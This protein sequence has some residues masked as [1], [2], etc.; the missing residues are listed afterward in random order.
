METSDNLNRQF[1]FLLAAIFAATSVYM[2]L[3]KSLLFLPAGAI[4]VVAFILALKRPSFFATPT[5][6]WMKFGYLI[7]KITNPVIIGIVYF[8]LICPTAIILRLLRKD[9]LSLRKKPSIKT[10][11]TPV[12]DENDTPFEQY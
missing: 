12:D 11:W 4:S 9:Q 7:S 6:H 3:G 8:C 10:Y 2:G 5:R 1:G